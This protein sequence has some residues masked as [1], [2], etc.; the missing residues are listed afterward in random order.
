MTL[1]PAGSGQLGA[2]Y[3]LLRESDGGVRL[4]ALPDGS[5]AWLVTRY[6]Q[7]SAA[8]ADPRLSLDKRNAIGWSGFSLPPDLDANLLNMDPPDHSRIRRLVARAFT[9]A[10]VRQWR[11]KVQLLA[12]DLLDA[13]AGRTS[14]D[15]IESYAGPLAVRAICDLLG[16]PPDRQA[17]FRA[18]TNTMLAAFPPDR[19]AMGRAVVDMRAFIIDLID[20]KRAN[21]GDDLL[22]VLVAVEDEGGSLS[23]EELTSLAFLLLFAGY[24]NSVNLIANTFLAI[25]TGPDPLASVA[26]DPARLHGII[27]E[28]LR[29]R[30][31]APVAIRRFPLVDLELGG[32]RIPAGDTVLLALAA[33]NRDPRAF[34]DAGQSDPDRAGRAHLSFGRGIHYCV[35]AALAR[36]E[37][38]VCVQTVG[39]RLP[40]LALAIPVAQVRWRPS[41]RTYGPS[42]LPIR[43]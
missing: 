16:V 6:E 10:Q 31:P 33:A 38:E 26:A 30:P 18:W 11:P 5:T 13:L 40:G 19:A 23:R 28:S 15:L 34:D 9:P 36:V 27:D 20:H 8:L 41:F 43:W 22:S 17:D 4:V 24:E 7:V 37:V 12:D 14:A 39:R 1:I 29:L 3:D 25:L 35:G 2:E 21:P 32:V 42:E